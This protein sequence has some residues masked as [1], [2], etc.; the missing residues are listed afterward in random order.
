MT[1]PTTSMYFLIIV[2]FLTIWN[3][4]WKN[5]C[6]ARI[7]FLFASD[8]ENDF[9]NIAVIILDYTQSL[10]EV[11]VYNTNQNKIIFSSL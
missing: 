7:R 9:D 3:I 6:H 4:F 10:K 8:P 2:L 11:T 1:I 5:D